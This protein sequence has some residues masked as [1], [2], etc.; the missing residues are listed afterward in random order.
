[1]KDQGQLLAQYAEDIGK[2]NM[3][4]ERM[5]DLQGHVL[6]YCLAQPEARPEPR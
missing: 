4:R 6:R 2:Y 3:L 5:L 1:V